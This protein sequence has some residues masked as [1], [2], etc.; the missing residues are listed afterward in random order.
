[1]NLN[2]H[3]LVCVTLSVYLLRGVHKQGIYGMFLFMTTDKNITTGKLVIDVSYF[4]IHVHSETHNFCDEISCPATGE[5]VLAS[6]QTLP[7]FT[8]PVSI[9]STADVAQLANC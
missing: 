3:L 8:P 6:K 4:I 9:T 7:S 2:T 1:M 5:F